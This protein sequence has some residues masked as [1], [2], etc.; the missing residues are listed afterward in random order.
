[1]FSANGA[2]ISFSQG[3]NESGAGIFRAIGAIA[4]DGTTTLTATNGGTL[5]SSSVPGLGLCFNVLTAVR[6]ENKN[7]NSA[8]FGD[9]LFNLCPGGQKC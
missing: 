6:F 3:I 1:V 5:I 7:R 9:V 4:M 8:S 2:T